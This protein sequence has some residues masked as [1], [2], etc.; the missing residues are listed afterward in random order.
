M[1]SGYSACGLNM[2]FTG[3]LTVSPF[4]FSADQGLGSNKQWAQRTSVVCAVQLLICMSSSQCQEG[5]KAEA[6]SCGVMKGIHTWLTVRSK[7]TVAAGSA[8]MLMMSL[9]ALAKSATRSSG[10]T[11][12]CINM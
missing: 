4:R 6:L 2:C 10:C 5:F 8:W 11:I 9:P 3:F 1:L 12:I 7:C